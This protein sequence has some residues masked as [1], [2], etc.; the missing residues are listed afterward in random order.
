MSNSPEKAG[1][2]SADWHKGLKVQPI[3]GRDRAFVT[4]LGFSIYPGLVN[5]FVAQAFGVRAALKGRPAIRS[6]PIPAGLPADSR[7]TFGVAENAN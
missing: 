6:N 4:K 3:I 2:Q 5:P 7:A 1:R